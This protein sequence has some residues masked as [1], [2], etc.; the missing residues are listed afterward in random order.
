MQ[1]IPRPNNFI[2]LGVEFNLKIVTVHIAQDWMRVNVVIETA[3]MSWQI[4]RFQKI[5]FTVS[6]RKQ[7][8]H[9]QRKKY[10]KSGTIKVISKS[11]HKQRGT[12]H[13]QEYGAFR[14]Y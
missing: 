13:F 11:G 8:L 12:I 10:K 14:F 4:Y 1:E 5:F 3:P 7:L 6:K 9:R 2:V